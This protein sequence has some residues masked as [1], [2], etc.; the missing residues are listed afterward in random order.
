[1]VC[2]MTFIPIS[3]TNCST[4]RTK[5]QEKSSRLAS[6]SVRVNYLDTIKMLDNFLAA[7]GEDNFYES[8]VSE[9]EE[10]EEESGECESSDRSNNEESE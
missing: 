4:G 9:A 7:N 1:M 6:T 8:E 3:I 5:V 2:H 10:S